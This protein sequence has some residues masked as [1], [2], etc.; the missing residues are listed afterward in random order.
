[1]TRRDERPERIGD[2][3]IGYD[4][5][6]VGRHAARVIQDRGGDRVGFGPLFSIACD[7]GW[8]TSVFD[9]LDAANAAA[10]L[11]VSEAREVERLQRIVDELR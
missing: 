2:D 5:I 8:S 1:M 6:V 7:C 3:F 10:E 9:T 11:H 4:P